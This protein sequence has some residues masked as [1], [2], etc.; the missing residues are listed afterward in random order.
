[1]ND[2]P[3]DA[4]ETRRWE[5]EKRGDE[6]VQGAPGYEPNTYAIPKCPPAGTLLRSRQGIVVQVL[7]AARTQAVY[8]PDSAWP[9]VDPQQG[10]VAIVGVTGAQPWYDVLGRYGPLTTI[11]FCELKP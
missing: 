4:D 10:I 1:M 2:R 3:E 7:D 9:R 8:A 11:G 6:L 5:Q